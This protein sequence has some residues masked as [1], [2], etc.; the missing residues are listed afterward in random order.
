[1]PYAE[2]D[3]RDFLR[4]IV[5]S[6]SLALVWLISTLAIGTY[7]DLLVPEKKLGI[8]NIIFYIWMAGSLVGLIWVYAR[9]WKK[10]FPHG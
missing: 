1:M 10:K 5:W 4:R 8:S 6:L 2:D 3:P 7:W 9:I